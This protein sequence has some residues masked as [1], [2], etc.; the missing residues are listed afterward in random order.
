MPGA[1]GVVL[2]PVQRVFVPG[3]WHP[4][5]LVRIAAQHR[6]AAGVR[7]PCSAQLLLPVAS[8]VP[9][10]RAASTRFSEASGVR[11]RRAERLG[12]QSRRFGRHDAVDAAVQ[13]PPDAARDRHDIAHGERLG[14]VVEFAELRRQVAPQQLDLPIDPGDERGDH[15]CVC[16]VHAHRLRARRSGRCRRSDAR[17]RWPGR[18]ARGSPP[19]GRARAGAADP[20]ATADP[21]PSR[22]RDRNTDRACWRRRHAGCRSGHARSRRGRPPRR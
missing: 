11:Y 12:Q 16:L 4:E 8:S 19:A 20:S 14:R 7:L 6:L 18:R 10:A 17:C 22:C 2:R 9:G 15:A 5:R 21:A 1:G 13:R 3:R